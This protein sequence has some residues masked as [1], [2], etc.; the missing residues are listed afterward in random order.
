M[1]NLLLTGCF[2]YTEEQK[3]ELAALGFRIWYMQ[4]ESDVLPLAAAEIDAVVCNGLFLHHQLDDFSR[5]RYIQLTSAGLDRVPVEKIRERN[6]ALFNARGVYSVPMAEW[7]V[8]RVLEYYKQADRFRTAQEHNAW[9][10]NRDLKELFRAQVA[11]V[12]A[13]N[14][15]QEVAKRF[16][17][18]GAHVFGFDIHRNGLPDFEEVDLIDNLHNRIENFD[19]VVITAPLTPSTRHLI[20]EDLLRKVKQHAI[21]VNIARGALI[22]EAALCRV[23]RNRPDIHAALDVFEIEPLPAGSPLWR[24][25][26]VSVSPHNSFVSNGNNRRM[27]D[28]IRTNLKN[29]I[30]Q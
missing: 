9:N 4:Q 5:L 20:S 6:I 23:L 13:G 30:L 28:L 2:D 16:G 17:A 22:D 14:V 25:P 12:G 3:H 26:N 15:G 11:I 1:T 8:F 7:A 19:I 27:F 21:L 24:L 10:K 29:H 18:F